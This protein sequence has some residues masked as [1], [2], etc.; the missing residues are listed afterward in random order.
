MGAAA[1]ASPRAA[2]AVS[3]QLTMMDELP[4]EARREMQEAIDRTVG[5]VASANRS[6]EQ[7]NDSVELQMALDHASAL[8]LRFQV[9]VE[10]VSP[11]GSGAPTPPQS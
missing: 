3:F 11:F 9:R 6:N 2:A 5:A 4:L 10:Q 1:S 8:L 7:L